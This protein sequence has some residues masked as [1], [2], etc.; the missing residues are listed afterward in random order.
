MILQEAWKRTHPEATAD[1]IFPALIETKL[2]AIFAKLISTRG[3]QHGLSLNEV[4]ALGNQ[5]EFSNF[6]S[7]AVQNWV[8]RD[9]KELIGHPQI[10]KKY[11]LEQ[12]AILFI[13]DD[14]KA[15]LDFESIRK[16][17]K[18]IFRKPE[19]RYDDIIDPLYLYHAYAAIFEK[20][21]H[22][23][24]L[25][26]IEQA[27]LPWKAQIEKMIAEEAD[28]FLQMYKLEPEQ[29]IIVKNVLI[30]AVLAA[31][32]SCFQAKTRKYVDATI[33]LYK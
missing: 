17:L 9:V 8:K 3:H 1:N 24:K 30:I 25:K 6:S 11:T 13:V 16:I 26:E 5:L 21:Q 33:F 27:V 14:L 28:N 22:R 32:N 19:V 2:P 15:S 7:A 23:S 10:G 18:L 29:T 31:F 20:M 4:A 12:A